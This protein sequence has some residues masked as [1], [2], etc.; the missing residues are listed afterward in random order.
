MPSHS[1][2]NRVERP[3]PTTVAEWSSGEREFARA[4]GSIAATP[5][6]DGDLAI[7]VTR[8]RD[9]VSL[10][11]VWHAVEVE[12]AADGRPASLTAGDDA[13]LTVHL[14][15]QHAQEH[16]WSEAGG[17]RP[18][19]ADPSQ[20]LPGGP[21]TA[22]QFRRGPVNFRA[23]RASR[24]VFD[25]PAG[26][27][28]AVDS[29]SILRLIPTLPLRVHEL[30]RPGE[31]PEKY[32]DFPPPSSLLPKP[33]WWRLSDDLIM[34]VRE[35]QVTVQVATAAQRRR[36]PLAEGVEAQRARTKELIDGIVQSAGSIQLGYGR[37]IDVTALPGALRPDPD[38]KPRAARRG[39][40]GSPPS[41][42]Q[43]SIEAPFRLVISPDSGARWTHAPEPVPAAADVRHVELWH[44]RLG[45]AAPG[46]EPEDPPGVT[47][48]PTRERIVR[49]VWARDRDHLTPAEWRSPDS[50]VG[51]EGAA[52]PAFAGPLAPP[53]PPSA[54]RHPFPSSLNRSDRHRIVRQSA[55]T[56]RTDAGAPIPPVPVG[57]DRLWLSALGA[58]LDLHGHWETLP[59]SG[60][61]IPSILA[62][63]HIATF[64]RDQFV[65]V[66]YPGYLFPLG[67]KAVLVK[68]TE[69]KIR[70]ETSDAYAPRRPIAGLWQRH[71]IAVIQRDR[72][73]IQQDLPFTHAHLGPAVTPTLDE[74]SSTN[75][76][77]WPTIGG[78]AYRF[79]VD[80]TDRAGDPL[81]FTAPLLWVAEHVKTFDAVRDAYLGFP[82]GADERLRRVIDLGGRTVALY[83]DEAADLTAH[84][85]VQRMRLTGV[86][87]LGTSE[88]HLSTADVV[89]EA[90]RRLADTPATTIAYHG[91]VVQGQALRA[92]GVWAAVATVGALADPA[93]AGRIAPTDPKLPAPP[94]IRFGEPPGPAGP[95][96]TSETGGGFVAPSQAIAGL[97]LTT[98]TVADLAQSV[99]GTFDPATALGSADVLAALGTALPKLFGLVPLIELLEAVGL[100]APEILASVMEPLTQLLDALRNVK[101]LAERAKDE[102]EATAKRVVDEAE[103]K[104]TDAVAGAEASAQAFLAAQQAKVAALEAEAAALATEAGGVV[105]DVVDFFEGLA[106]LDLDAARIAFD[107][108]RARLGALAGKLRTIGAGLLP[109]LVRTR[110]AD[111]AGILDDLR[112]STSV[113]DDVF[114]A[115]KLVSDLA[116]GAKQV[117][118]HFDWKPPLK[119]WPNSAAPILSFLPRDG[120]TKRPLTISVTG[121]AGVSTTPSLK[122][123]AELR[124]F[125]LDLLP[126]EPLLQIEFEHLSFRSGTSGK[127]EV[128][129]VLRTVR[130]VGILSFVE[131]IKE[132]IPFD[133]FS[134]PPDISVDASGLTAGYTLA[135]PNV[136]IGVFALSNMS[137][138]ADL[139]V[140]FL[141]DGLSVGFGFCS[142]ERP[143]TLAVVFLGGGG[144]F[145]MRM[146]PKRLEL[147]E[148]GL[149]AGA[150][151]SVDFGVASGSISAAIG[152]YLRMESDKGSLTGYFRLRGEVDVLGLISASIELAMSL[153]YDFAEQKV[154]GRASITVEVEVLFFSASVTIEAERK[155]AGSNGDP[156]VREIITAA[157]GDTGAWSEYLDAFATEEP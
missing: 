142:R 58:T 115:A 48:E 144:W 9:L 120:V 138:S 154:I 49:A 11:T 84:H 56:W 126:I 24:L 26:T 129:V 153:T 43:T 136:A 128:D 114:Q 54:D 45:R 68:I 122:I 71:F 107:A 50:D 116:S 137:L 62:W 82:G 123:L 148:I 143:F 93:I 32:P 155:F 76:F 19:P 97:S 152:I 131:T 29:P 37:G 135:L 157:G 88:P 121:T 83:R 31:A 7:D 64:G 132:L 149:E 140:P 78:G 151:L 99:D 72:S 127:T 44:T 60:S 150:Y 53:A 66:V 141:G 95:G 91:D 105:D 17:S 18:N 112:T 110:L 40:Y 55:E 21:A 147:L 25:L 74:P 20:T 65:R 46:A 96:K 113:V 89:V 73:Y 22:S 118:L 134:D 8:P 10:L 1:R 109:P 5:I 6:P 119:D 51:D 117:E 77:F 156:S 4:P 103:Q 146:S 94:G 3:A 57:A 63:D 39:E 111:A 70:V 16:T 124:E 106:E 28:V 47:E 15:F 34:H 86:A 67:H 42:D 41:P 104:V 98:G 14:P 79:R 100:E 27:R 80:G 101:T 130:F 69:R 59:Y 52:P 87:R 81:P 90:A 61:G 133:G 30:A 125:S 139:R 38:A 85:E 35:S 36:Y 108:F 13:T 75:T 92:G 23:A 2:K 145:A 12:G 102:A 33:G